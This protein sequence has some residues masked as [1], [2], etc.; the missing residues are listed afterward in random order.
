MPTTKMATT[1]CDWVRRK[2]RG[3]LSL[4]AE[5]FLRGFIVASASSKN[6]VAKV[7]DP[8]L[9]DRRFIG[10]NGKP[11]LSYIRSVCVCVCPKRDTA[12]PGIQGTSNGTGTCTWY[13]VC[14]LAFPFSRHPRTRYE[15]RDLDRLAESTGFPDVASA[16]LQHPAIWLSV[17]C[18][19]HYDCV[20]YFAPTCLYVD[21]ST[22]SNTRFLQAA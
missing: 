21:S 5:G 1:C 16:E 10:Y 20:G 8:A 11:F 6:V 19:C 9:R 2:S 15:R 3:L 22:C 13:L 18:E 17:R 12:V 14:M 4:I 7:N